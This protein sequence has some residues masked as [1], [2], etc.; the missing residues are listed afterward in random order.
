MLP[1]HIH[2]IWSL[3]RGDDDYARR[4]AF[5]K[6]EFMRGWLA[7]GGSEQ[8]VGTEQRARHRRGVWQPRFWEHVIQDE[9]DFE[10]HLDYIHYN[11]VKHGLVASPGDWPYSSF[12]RWVRLGA[13]DPEWGRGSPEEYSHR[14]HG[15]DRT[16]GESGAL[17]APRRSP[18]RPGPRR[19]LSRQVSQ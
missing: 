5:I 3:P 11:P 17:R 19:V 4:S 12:H 18:A 2:A 13:Y 7:S 14:F 15:L 8:V 9:E 6:K 16:V 1:E 10:R